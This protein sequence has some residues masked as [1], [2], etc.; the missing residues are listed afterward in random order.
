MT[1]EAKTKALAEKI[2]DTC[3]GTN[4]GETLSALAIAAASI[5]NVAAADG[6]SNEQMA[7]AFAWSFR[8]ALDGM[9]SEPEGAG[10]Q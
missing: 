1:R 3:A 2:L 10:L 7:R 5:A 9:R 4:A 6:V 8:R